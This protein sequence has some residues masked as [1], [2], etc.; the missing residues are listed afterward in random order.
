[1]DLRKPK[2]NFNITEKAFSIQNF[3][4]LAENFTSIG[5]V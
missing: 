3:N 4:D 1:M 5:L 2:P